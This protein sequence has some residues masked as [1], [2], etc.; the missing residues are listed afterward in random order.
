VA[1]AV[2][3]DPLTSADRAVFDV[4]LIDVRMAHGDPTIGACFNLHFQFLSV[5]IDKHSLSFIFEF[6]FI[7]G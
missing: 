4:A 1:K 3:S 2:A 6:N 5:L 7:C